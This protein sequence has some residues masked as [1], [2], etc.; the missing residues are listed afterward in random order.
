[1]MNYGDSLTATYPAEM[2]N[3]NRGA[4]REAFD[5]LNKETDVASKI[6]AELFERMTPYLRPAG[7]EPGG[8]DGSAEVRQTP[9]PFAEEMESVAFKTRR[10]NR[11]LEAIIA[12]LDF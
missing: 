11:Q 3:G 8:I 1:L 2:K 6:I 12:R 9:S 4:A 7:P 5:R 10:N